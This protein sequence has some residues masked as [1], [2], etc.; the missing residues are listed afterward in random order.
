M[1]ANPGHRFYIN[2]MFDR[3]DNPAS[4]RDG[5]RHGA[6]GNVSLNDGSAMQSKGKQWIPDG[7]HLVLK[8][9]GGGGYGEPAERDR[10]LVEQDLIRGYISE[11]EAKEIYLRED[12]E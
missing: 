9:P 6:P 4:G 7:K 1:S 3:C 8:L 2:A 11:D 5:G 10:A 12:P